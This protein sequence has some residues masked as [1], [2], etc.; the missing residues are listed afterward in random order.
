MLKYEEIPLAEGYSYEVDN[1][2]D[3]SWYDVLRGFD[4]ANLF[5]TWAFA[6]V[7]AGRRNLCAVLLKQ[8]GEIVAAGLVRIKRVPILGIGLAYVHRGPLWRRR[9]VERNINDLRQALRALRN[10][11][12]CKRGLTLR[13]HPVLFD[14]DP[15]AASILAEESFD[16]VQNQI[17]DQTIL[18]DLTPSIDDLRKGF[19]HKWKQDLKRAEENHLHV[20]EG[21]DDCLVDQVIP[22]YE[23]MVSRKSFTGSKGIYKFKEIQARLPEDFKIRISLCM[24]DEEVCAGVA[25]SAI[26][27]MGVLLYAATSNAGRLCKASYLL[28]W[29][30]VNHLRQQGCVCYNL[31]GIDPIKNPG[32]YRFKKRLGG[33]HG[34][35][36]FYLGKFDASA[37]SLSGSLIRL[38]DK[39]RLRRRKRQP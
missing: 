36:V 26:G 18:M 31:N 30:V 21:T 16:Q 15:F 5:Q 10:E 32:T 4:D 9:G 28:Q 29:K 39:I 24:A 1:R 7:A 11:F 23:E 8:K 35:E 17:R 13:V 12:V 27:E 34:R 3:N 38:R 25:W 19:D 20:T 22:L 14:D 2:D 33:S 6:E 37:G